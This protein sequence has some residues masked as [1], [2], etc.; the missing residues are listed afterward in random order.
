[1]QK[2]CLAAV[3]AIA[4]SLGTASAQEAANNPLITWHG[5]ATLTNVP[6]ACANTSYV[7]GDSAFSVFRPRLDPAE[8][9]SAITLT[10][11]RSGFAFFRSPSSPSG[12]DQMHGTSSYTSP[13]YSG[14]AT[15]TA[16]GNTGN[17]TLTLSPS[18]VTAAT[19]VITIVG[20]I[21]KFHG[22]VGCNVQFK[23]S[24]YRRPN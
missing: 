1:M 22:I 18:T 6:A 9:N 12:T 13:W 24:Y 8:P 14:R 23:G 10:F 4:A 15:S 16:G 17:I 2:F 19:N 20:T 5:A 21:T 7:V 11:G 3:A